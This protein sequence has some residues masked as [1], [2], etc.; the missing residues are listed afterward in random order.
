MAEQPSD[1]ITTIHKA[2]WAAPNDDAHGVDKQL[3]AVSNRIDVTADDFDSFKPNVGADDTPELVI[4]QG[5]GNQ[6]DY[7]VSDPA[8]QRS[9]SFA[10]IVT[11]DKLGPVKV[12]R[13]REQIL[14]SLL[15]AGPRLGVP[16][17]NANTVRSWSVSWLDAM[18]A[19]NAAGAGGDREAFRFQVAGTL[20]VNFIKA[21][22][23]RVM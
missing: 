9:Q 10:F 18:N 13:I 6:S 21:V 15:Y 20:T 23:R 4:I 7:A 2:V 1:I 14:D 12:N 22:P 17:T 5:A 8:V 3:V 16:T 19:V 11:G